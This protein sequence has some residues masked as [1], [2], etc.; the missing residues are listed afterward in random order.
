MSVSI[1]SQRQEQRQ[2][3]AELR[4]QRKTWAEVGRV[5]SDRYHVNARAAM[6]MAH[7]WSQ[8]DAAERWNSRW[9]A[10]SKTFKNFSYWELWPAS[11]GYAPSLDVLGRLAELYECSI[12]DLVWDC[13]DF[14]DRD[15]I[16]GDAGRLHGLQALLDHGDDKTR[17]TNA[18]SLVSKLE[19]IDVTELARLTASWADSLKGASRR[20]IL[21]KLS[22]AL[23]LAAAA[24]ALADES[25]EAPPASGVAGDYEG[26]WHSRYIY[27]STSRGGNVSGDH[28]VVMRQ[29]G[30]QLFGQSVPATNGSLLNLDLAVSGPIATGIWSERTSLTG[31]Y[32][33]AVYHGAIQLIIDPMGKSMTGKWVG[34]DREFTIN[35]GEWTLTWQEPATTKGVQRAYHLKV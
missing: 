25:E 22:A 10:D 34:Y 30:N 29:R 31:H 35:S 1:R 16:H 23:S 6:R 26:I 2:L 5:F 3:S 18:A 9:P 27:P 33:G 7:G 8:R 17:P 12:S 13:G 24:P 15:S 28:Y 11:T 14:R 20:S 21:L 19:S 4:A 32:R